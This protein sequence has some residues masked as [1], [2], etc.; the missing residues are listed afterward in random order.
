M[1]LIVLD[2]SLDAYSGHHLSLDL[3]VA[4]HFHAQGAECLILA[5]KA[6]PDP[7]VEGIPIRPF[8]QHTAYGALDSDR[9]A[10]AYDEFLY[11]NNGVFEDLATLPPDF[12]RPGDI[13]FVPTVTEKILE[14]ILRWYAALPRIAAQDKA[15]R[16]VVFLMM[17]SGLYFDHGAQ[18][19][20]T[21]E[22]LTALF[23]R[24][25]LRKVAEASNPV[26]LIGTGREHAREYAELAGAHIP[27]FALMADTSLDRI[28]ARD[29]L[30]LPADS[31]IAVLYAGDCK[32]DKGF[33]SLPAITEHLCAAYPDWTFIIHFNTRA[34][35]GKALEA[36]EEVRRLA[37]THSNCI[38]YEGFLPSGT[39]QQIIAGADLVLIPYDREHYRAKSS[40][41]LWEALNAGCVVLCPVDCW[42]EKELAAWHGA[43][44]AYHGADVRQIAAAFA[45]LLQDFE[46]EQ[47]IAA[48]AA[49]EFQRAN[50]L[51]TLQGLM[52]D[53]GPR[54][55]SFAPNREEKN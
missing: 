52:V 11:F 38:L 8:F 33:S 43:G 24:L 18:E 17:P 7:A 46:A 29:A 23:Y 25:A 19:P 26:R 47:R 55:L 35:W 20:Q 16:L 44:K 2:P 41:I 37:G 22:P 50:G 36:A 27:A 40:G 14:G 31:R 48:K 28:A 53:N 21:I 30:T 34:A 3:K 13:L 15:L 45:D 9:Y 5:N 10:R 42:L 6:F 49:T 54:S 39:Y 12:L 32:A 1:R 51:D 4:Q